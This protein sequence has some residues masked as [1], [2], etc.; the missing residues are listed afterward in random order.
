MYIQNKTFCRQSWLPKWNPLLI[1]ESLL[2]F[3]STMGQDSLSWN[4]QTLTPKQANRERMADEHSRRNAF[5]WNLW[6]SSDVR[7]LCFSSRTTLAAR[8]YSW[9]ESYLQALT[10]GSTTLCLTTT[11]TTTHM[12]SFFCLVFL[13]AFVC[14]AWSDHSVLCDSGRHLVTWTNTS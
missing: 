10:G 8:E 13:P 12:M 2:F 3:T 7:A 11:T 5:S 1:S 9:Y 14:D 4:R 6:L